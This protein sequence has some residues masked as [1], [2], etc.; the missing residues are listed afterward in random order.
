MRLADLIRTEREKRDWSQSRLGREAL[1][2]AS[3]VS[4]L[5][6]GKRVG[7][8]DTIARITSVLAIDPAIVQDYLRER[9]PEREIQYIDLSKVPASQRKLL[10]STVEALVRERERAGE[11]KLEGE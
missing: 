11:E 2:S 6:S 1:V 3:V 10:R 9:Q 4:R 5:E 7:R 8:A